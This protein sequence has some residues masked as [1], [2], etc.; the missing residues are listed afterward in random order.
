MGCARPWRLPDESTGIALRRTTEVAEGTEGCVRSWVVRV[1][2]GSARSW[3]SVPCSPLLVDVRHPPMVVAGHQP[4]S[5]GLR[6]RITRNNRCL[7]RPR[8][9]RSFGDRPRGDRA[10]GVDLPWGLP[11]PLSAGPV[12][13]TQ[14]SMQAFDLSKEPW[15]VDTVVEFPPDELDQPTE[16]ID[17]FLIDERPGEGRARKQCK[18]R[19]RRSWIGMGASNTNDRVCRRDEVTVVETRPGPPTRP[20]MPSLPRFPLLPPQK[21][22]AESL[23]SFPLVPPEPTAGPSPKPKRGVPKGP[24]VRLPRFSDF[25]RCASPHKR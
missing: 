16:E 23:P 8:G 17:A 11:S 21:T 4:G 12:R 13:A 22:S 9:S 7:V 3:F 14:P 6:A 10:F 15:D 18:P 25:D 5:D 1:A 24:P 2:P 20:P 19:I